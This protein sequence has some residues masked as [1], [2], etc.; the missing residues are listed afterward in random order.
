VA[1]AVAQIMAVGQHLVVLAV[2]LEMMGFLVEQVQRDKDMLVLNLFLQLTMAAAVVV[3]QR[4]QTI[5]L[6]LVV[7]M[8]L[9]L[10]QAG[11]LQHRLVKM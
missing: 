2:V 8:D 4:H 5:L 11:A 9:L 3:H 1:V 10:T 7:E 6:L